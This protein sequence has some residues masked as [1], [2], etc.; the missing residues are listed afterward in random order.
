MRHCALCFSL[1][2]PSA[3]WSAD[4]VGELSEGRDAAVFATVGDRVRTAAREPSPGDRLLA[5]FSETDLGIGAE[6]HLA[7][8]ALPKE[9]EN[10][11]LRPGRRDGQL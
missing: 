11:F 1:R 7:G 4:L 3:S 2:K 8:V 9:A 10:P 5:G 6:T